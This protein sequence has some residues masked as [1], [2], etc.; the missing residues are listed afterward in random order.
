[1]QV[2]HDAFHVRPD[3]RPLETLERLVFV[4]ADS[5]DVRDPDDVR[6]AD[7]ERIN[8]EPIALCSMQCPDDNFVG[9]RFLRHDMVSA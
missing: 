3:F 4:P 1:M 9:R 5:G 7:E 2:I 8:I 6:T